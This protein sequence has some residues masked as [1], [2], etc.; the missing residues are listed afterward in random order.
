MSNKK[1]ILI[2][3]LTGVLML[4]VCASGC[5]NSTEENNT[6]NPN[7][8]QSSQVLEKNSE[9]ASEMSRE[10]SE[11]EKS[12]VPAQSSQQS[13][14][15]KQDQESK[16]ESKASASSA[17][18]SQT[19]KQNTVSSIIEAGGS[20]KE[21]YD[22]IYALDKYR[23]AGHVVTDVNND[24]KYEL[25]TRNEDRTQL[26]IYKISGSDLIEMKFNDPG[27]GLNSLR[28]DMRY[29]TGS[30][31]VYFTAIGTNDNQSYRMKVFEFVPGQFVINETADITF[32]VNEYRKPEMQNMDETGVNVCNK[33]QFAWTESFNDSFTEGA[34]SDSVEIPQDQLGKYAV[35][36]VDNYYDEKDSDSGKTV[37]FSLDNSY[38]GLSLYSV[39]DLLLKEIYARHGMRSSYAYSIAFFN[40]KNYYNELFDSSYFD[41]NIVNSSEFN[42]FERIAIKT[43]NYSD[44]PAGQRDSYYS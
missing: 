10:S 7:T 15:S 40:K 35:D 9:T 6:E 2:L 21:I 33:L 11:S 25:I 3:A 44:N 31:D 36:F 22:N 38:K 20:Q 18:E 14:E 23:S 16:T 41:D 28:F 19:E 32:K 30:N 4:S 43:F 13:A 37:C 8:L 5:G 24:G 29:S 26:M 39:Q 42:D 34:P 12:T 1:R 27:F 17:E